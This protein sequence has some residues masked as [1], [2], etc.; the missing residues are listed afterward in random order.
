V[1]VIPDVVEVA[2][3]LW[4]VARFTALPARSHLELEIA[5][6]PAELAGQLVPL[7]DEAPSITVRRGGVESVTQCEAVCPLLI[8]P[9]DGPVV[10][11]LDGPNPA[12][13]V[14]LRAP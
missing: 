6:A 10:L 7:S 12:F 14:D 3:E 8:P 5:A 9:G 4:G 2:E 1:Q 11:R 13:A